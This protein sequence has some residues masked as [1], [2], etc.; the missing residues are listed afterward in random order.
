MTA[1]EFERLYQDHFQEIYRF[2]LRYARNP[3]TAMDLTQDVFFKAI[4][5]LS[6]NHGKIQNYRAWRF[7]IARNHCIT[8]G[9]KRM[10]ERPLAESDTLAGSPASSSFEEALLNSIEIDDIIA[11]VEE[12]YSEKE[13]QIFF[14]YVL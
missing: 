8:S 7:G 2:A 6:R 13:A 3:E 10:T 14:L 9:K 12:R 4:D 11:F 1:S 5:Y